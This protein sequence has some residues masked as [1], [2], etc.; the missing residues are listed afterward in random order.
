M[1]FKEVQVRTQKNTGLQMDQ[2]KKHN[3]QI[4]RKLV[5]VASATS[6]LTVGK[7]ELSFVKA[8]ASSGYTVIAP[9]SPWN[10]SLTSVLLTNHSC[11]SDAVKPSN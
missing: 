5:L 2:I 1:K 11:V 3:L 10:S 7:T 8:L 9:L 4:A 6:L